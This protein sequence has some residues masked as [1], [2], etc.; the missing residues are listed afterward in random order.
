[1]TGI[2]YDHERVSFNVARLKKGGKVFEVVVDSD[3]AMTFREGKNISVEDVL[4][5][6]QIFTDA[7][8]G[9]VASEKE[10]TEIFGTDNPLEIAERIIKEGEVQLTADYRNKL[11]EEKKRRI[12]EII[13]KNSIDPTTK[14]PHPIARIENAMNEAK[15]RIDEHKP[16]EDQVAEI[17]KKLKPILQIRFAVKEIAVKIPASDAP[18]AYSIV[19]GMSSIIKEEWQQDGSWISV[20]RIPAGIEQEFYDKLNSITHGKSETRVLKTEER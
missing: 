7:K 5:S 19:K 18:K 14:L 15:V 20:I 3:S 9:L 6:E 13:H 11:R 10:L 17:L 4:K 2:T 8:K 12:I 16:A 1:M